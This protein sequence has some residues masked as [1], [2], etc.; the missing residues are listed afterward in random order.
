MFDYFLTH[1]VFN[2]NIMR[3]AKIR[4]SEYAQRKAG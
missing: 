1:P 2:K 4:E 3:L